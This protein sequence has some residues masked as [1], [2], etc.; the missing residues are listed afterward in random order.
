MRRLAINRLRQRQPVDEATIDRFLERHE[1]PIIEG[2]KCTFCFRGAADE[3][4]VCHRIVGQ[5]QRVPMRRLGETSLWFTVL[6]L[7][8]GSRVEYQIEVRRGDHYEQGNDPLNPHV[9]NS[10]VGS[11]SVCAGAGYQ[12]PD[13]LTPDPDARPGEILDLP[14]PSKALRRE[15]PCRVYLPARFSDLHSYPLLIV[16]DGDDYLNYAAM[17][18]VLDNLIDRL[19]MAETIVV[20]TNP[21]DRNVEYANSSRHARFIAA[22]LL[23]L[24]EERFPLLGKPS[25]RCLMG[26]SFGGV[27]SLSTA[28]RYPDLFGSLLLQSGSFVFT[29]IGQD[30]GGGEVFDPVV[31]FM[32]RYRS[33]PRKV[34][35]RA[36]ISCGVY[37]P[38][39]VQNRSMVPVFDGTGMQIRYVEARD[40]HSWEDW[41][42]RL[43][44]GLSWIYPG[45][46][47]YY[48]E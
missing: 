22:E 36:F 14:V 41:R 31:R 29:D 15:A 34:A 46:Q 7:P 30:H 32:N 3:V 37:E 2:S 25:G 38:L 11:S 8:D 13:W 5:P 12:V 18:T 48:Y 43:G 44:E 10:P 47:K 39:I 4:W 27:A 42:D 1:M 17:K 24:L 19:D 9:A 45:P 35:E 20:F 40:G 33:N 16:H 23:P 26:A 6:E 21:G 28:Y